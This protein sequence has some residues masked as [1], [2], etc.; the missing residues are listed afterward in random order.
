MRSGWFVAAALAL[1]GGTTATAQ[2]Q[3]PDLSELAGGYTYYNRPGASVEQHNR[4]LSGCVQKTVMWSSPQ[5]AQ[6]GSLGDSLVFQLVWAGSIAGY[7]ASRI[8]NCMV[9]RGWRV[10]DIGAQEGRTLAGVPVEALVARLTPEVGA[11]TPTGTIVRRWANEGLR[12]GSYRITSR[13]R[14]PSPQQLS[15][16]LYTETPHPP[17]TPVPVP[18]LS[19]IDRVWPKGRLQPSQ[20]GSG[21]PGSAIILVRTF[22]SKNGA[23]IS[24]ARIGETTEDRPGVRDRAPDILNA[25]AEISFA[26]NEGNWF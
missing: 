17:V 5:A 6:P 3:R 4:E 11:E 18:S 2:D 10:V 15:L 12:P 7:K 22:S 13:A 16:R 26:K 23:G 14:K 8:E 19:T 25:N 9:V 1:T 21:P 20:L 24:F